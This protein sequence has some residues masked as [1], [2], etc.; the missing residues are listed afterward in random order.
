MTYTSR[1]TGSAGETLRSTEAEK[2]VL[3]CC[4]L[5]PVSVI[6]IL[7]RV[8]VDMFYAERH[9]VIWEAIIALTEKA[10][11]P[12][13]LTVTEELRSRKV[14]AAVGGATYL[15]SLSGEVESIASMVHYAEI[16]RQRYIRRRMVQAAEQIKEI[17]CTTDGDI[18]E[19]AAEAEKLLME[20]TKAEAEGTVRLLGEAA[21]EFWDYVYGNRDEGSI[22]TKTGFKGLD[23]ATGG[24]QRGDMIVLAARP[25]E[26]KTTL[27]MQ[28]AY[29]VAKSGKPVIIFSLEMAERQVANRLLVG[30]GKF[31]NQAIRQRDLGNAE[32]DVG[33]DLAKK[34]KEL[35]LFVDDQA[36]ATLAQIRARARR[37]K[38]RQGDLGLVVVDYLQLMR[39][40]TGKSREEQ[41][42]LIAQGMKEMAKELD[43]PVLVL[44]QLNRA[45][46]YQAGKRPMLSNLRESGNIEQAADVVIFIH[47][48]DEESNNRELLIE[49]QRMLPTGVVR[50]LSLDERAWFREVV[51]SMR[52]APA[53]VAQEAERLFRR[54]KHGV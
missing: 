22:G 36:G 49:K 41:I 33:F 40:T 28:I 11:P 2:A 18:N 29:N 16:V 42:G 15:T 21:Q 35:P 23:R 37:L 1:I 9:R 8:T 54:G 31:D 19:Q 27:A 25:G 26:G 53:P 47:Q 30:L 48:P 6:E 12:D 43:V 24:F 52:P 14:L 7:D 10:I 4:L 50:G 39:P 3:G 5:D 45:V 13:L 46:E 32:W 17:A 44:S 38:S 20:A 34:L 51:V